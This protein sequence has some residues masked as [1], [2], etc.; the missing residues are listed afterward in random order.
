MTEQETLILQVKGLTTGDEPRI[1][2]LANVA[3]AI[4]WAL[5]SVNWAGFYFTRAEIESAGEVASGQQTNEV[6]TPR[7][8]DVLYLGP[9]V[10]QVA[11]T[12]IPFGKGVCGKAAETG[13]VQRIAD[14][15]A[16]PGHIACDAASRSELVIPLKHAGHVVGVIDLDSPERDRFSEEDAAALQEVAR[17]VERLW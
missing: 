3:A 15:H 10:G 16:F 14:V 1:T 13:A 5:K 12:T 6:Q 2:K 7:G 8:N 9:F 11:C 4:Y 17:L